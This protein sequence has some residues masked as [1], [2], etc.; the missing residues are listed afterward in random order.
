M[1]FSKKTTNTSFV[2]LLIRRRLITLA[3]DKTK[4]IK[5]LL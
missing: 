5:P 4:V 2:T 1:S 3:D